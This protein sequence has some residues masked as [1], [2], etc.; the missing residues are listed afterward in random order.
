MSSTL[1]WR[2]EQEY[3]GSLPDQLKFVLR[4]RISV[5]Y[6]GEMTFGDDDLA[7]LQGLKDA[8]VEGAN[9]L[10]ELIKTHG[11]ITVQEQF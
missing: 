5:S 3:Q 11:N 6:G 1:M 8:G 9:H 2:P 4:N 7:Y 10:I